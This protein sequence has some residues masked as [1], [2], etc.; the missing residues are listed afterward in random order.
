MVAW[1]GELYGLDPLD[2]YQLLTQI[3]R[4]PLA[5]VVDANYS[6]V[7]RVEKAL[8]PAADAYQ[9]VHRRLRE[10]ARTI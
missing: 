5:N 4:S 3:S 7:T 9:G 6:A 2:A 10:L 1:L 8:L